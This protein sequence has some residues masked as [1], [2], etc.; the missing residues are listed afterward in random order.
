[1][2]GRRDGQ[3]ISRLLALLH[4]RR[5]TIRPFMSGSSLFSLSL[6][7]VYQFEVLYQSKLFFHSIALFLSLEV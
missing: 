7:F 4:L 1:M 2:L 5:T 6:K 3:S